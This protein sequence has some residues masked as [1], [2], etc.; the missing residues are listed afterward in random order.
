MVAM[1]LSAI[2]V[3]SLQ[4]SWHA[5]GGSTFVPLLVAMLI[6]FCVAAIFYRYDNRSRTVRLLGLALALGLFV[7]SCDDAI[8][9]FRLSH[10]GDSSAGL[11]HGVNWLQLIYVLMYGWLAFEVVRMARASNHRW[12]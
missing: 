2:L 9:T 5:L 3:G 1:L 4:R 6:N 12:K 7:V 10:T 8:Q 11:G